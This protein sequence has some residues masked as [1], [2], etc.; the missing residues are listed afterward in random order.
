MAYR[1][2]PK[3]HKAKPKASKACT[4][5]SKNQTPHKIMGM[6]CRTPQT[7]KVKAEVSCT[8]RSS[9]VIKM[10][11]NPLN[12]ASRIQTNDVKDSN[13]SLSATAAIITMVKTP[14][15]I[16]RAVTSNLD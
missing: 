9:V 1:M 4:S 11:S 10:E 7:K 15:G 14:K 2:V 8:R 5:S 6:L 3:R 12:S 13:A 16:I